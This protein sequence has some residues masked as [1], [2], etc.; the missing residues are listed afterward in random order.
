MVR[1]RELE[2]SQRSAQCIVSK[3][4]TVKLGG[5]GPLKGHCRGEFANS[6]GLVGGQR[7][8]GG[9]GRLRENFLEYWRLGDGR[10][11]GLGDK[12][13]GNRSITVSPLGLGP[14]PKPTPPLRP[15]TRILTAILLCAMSRTW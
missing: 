15:L 2:W 12:A 10:A 1:K 4:S 3:C 11:V 5:R 14:R 8:L 9:L 7:D 13:L 6:S